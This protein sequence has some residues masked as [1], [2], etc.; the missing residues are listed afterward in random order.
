MFIIPGQ[1]ISLITFPGVIIHEV[2]HLLF[3]KIFNVKVHE[4]CFYQFD[5][6]A[7][8]VTHEELDSPLKVFMISTGPLIINTLIGGLVG[9]SAAVPAYEFGSFRFIDVLVI[10]LGISIA[11]HSFPSSSDSQSIRNF[12]KNNNVSKII[13]YTFTPL[14]Y[15]FEVASALSVVWIDFVYGVFVVYGFSK[16]FLL[17]AI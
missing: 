3:C 6:V 1:L 10:W 4:I 14:S 13:K 8:Y 2:A 15:V 17:L 11:M 12:V 16:L 7:G 9:L 5:S